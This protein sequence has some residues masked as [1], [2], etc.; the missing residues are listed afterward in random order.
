LEVIVIFGGEYADK[1][2]LSGLATKEIHLQLHPLPITHS[3]WLRYA[4]PTLTTLTKSVGCVI[5]GDIVSL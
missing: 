5:E 1:I 2:L 4:Y 3:S